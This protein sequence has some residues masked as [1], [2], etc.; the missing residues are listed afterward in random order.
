M[1]RTFKHEVGATT[2]AAT[3]LLR[4]LK[5]LPCHVCPPAIVGV[6]WPPLGRFGG[7]MCR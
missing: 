4:W 2:G 1:C 3:F 5:A 7:N 6:R